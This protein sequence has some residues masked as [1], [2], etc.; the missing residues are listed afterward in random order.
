MRKSLISILSSFFR[1]LENCQLYEF[2]QSCDNLYGSLCQLFVIEFFEMSNQ[3]IITKGIVVGD[4][5]IYGIS[6]FEVIVI[7]D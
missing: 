6:L 5:N 3:T 1:N 7:V 2:A 4:I